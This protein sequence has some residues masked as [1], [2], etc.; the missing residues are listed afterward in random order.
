VK[1]DLQAPPLRIARGTG[2]RIGVVINRRASGNSGARARAQDLAEILGAKGWVAIPGSFG[3]L[4]EVIGEFREREIGVLAACGGDGTFF[5]TL[6]AMLQVYDGA[7]RP[8]F[9]PL[10]AGAMNTIAR[11]VGCPA[12]KPERMLASVVNAGR[13]QSLELTSRAL[14][15]VNNESF[16]FMAGAG[17]IVSFLQAYYQAPRQGPWGALSLLARL[18][19]SAIAGGAEAR[20]VLRWL[21]AEV[22]CDGTRVPFA[23]YSVIY[24]GTIADIGL[25]FRP[26]YRAAESLDHF[27]CLA[28][29]IQARE[30]IRRLGRIRRG[31]ATGSPQLY[32]GIAQRLTVEF[33]TAEPY[34]IDGDVLEPVRRLT[35]EVGPEL[36]IIRRV[37]KG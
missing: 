7:P 23:T 14:L 31:V 28:G 35:I 20:R 21:D 10:R 37:K 30:L 15:C 5:R 27:H 16:G 34:M 11:G 36:R 29:P 22:T 13:E 1:R 4:S 9:L 17:T 8:V 32:D 18:A 24:A 3:E 26:A 33:R 12:W 25:G 19:A 6:T 2:V